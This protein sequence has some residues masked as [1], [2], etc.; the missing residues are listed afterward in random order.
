M[1]SDIVLENEA[2]QILKSKNEPKTKITAPC[3]TRTLMSTIFDR[4]SRFVPRDQQ[5][6]WTWHWI[7]KSHCAFETKSFKGNTKTFWRFF[8]VASLDIHSKYFYFYI[9]NQWTVMVSAGLFISE[10]KQH[11]FI[12]DVRHKL[13]ALLLFDMTPA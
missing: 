1:T 3:C 4:I 13:F 11:V 2:K 8:A 7:A 9:R 10:K 6:N 5:F 12:C